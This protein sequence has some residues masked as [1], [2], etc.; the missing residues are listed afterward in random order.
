[1][2]NHDQPTIWARILPGLISSPWRMSQMLV[3]HLT[4]NNNIAG[5]NCVL[6]PWK[7][8]EKD[9]NTLTYFNQLYPTVSLSQWRKL[10]R[11]PTFSFCFLLSILYFFCQATVKLGDLLF[12]LLLC[13]KNFALAPVKSTTV[14]IIDQSATGPSLLPA[15]QR[16]ALPFVLQLP[17]L[18]A[19]CGQKSKNP[20]QMMQN[21]TN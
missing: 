12:S 11:T 5:R 17:F 13:R 1:M 18:P 10:M 4:C 2:R 6:H 8:F 21:R 7:L 20:M 19:F 14:R 15:H 9:Q 16:E 3:C